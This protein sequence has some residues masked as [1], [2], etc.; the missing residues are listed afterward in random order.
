MQP[1]TPASLSAAA[2]DLLLHLEASSWR[3]LQETGALRELGRLGL[4][5]LRRRP[6]QLPEV[7]LTG[8][9]GAVVAAARRAQGIAATVERVGVPPPQL[10]KVAVR[11]GVAFGSAFR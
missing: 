11:V 1:P 6:G 4:V 2:R 10:R 5:E 9:G 8:A 3:A 7:R